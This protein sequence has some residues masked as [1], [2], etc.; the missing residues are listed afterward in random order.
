MKMLKK[1]IAVIVLF[2]TLSFIAGCKE[3]EIIKNPVKPSDGSSLT[4]SGLSGTEAGINANNSVFVD[5]SKDLQSSYLRRGWDLGFYCGTEFRVIINHS[6]GATA[7]ALDKTNLADVSDADLVALPGGIGSLDMGTAAISTV[8]PV[9]GNFTDYLANTVWKDVTT[10]NNKV[11]ILNRGIAG[12]I[13]TLET[14]KVQVT[15]ITGGYEVQYSTPGGIPGVATTVVKDQSYSFKYL[16][17]LSRSTLSVEPAKKLWD[18]EYTVTTYKDA[19]GLPVVAP[20]FILINFA[21][22]VTAAEIVFGSNTSK[23]YDSF[24]TADLSGVVFSGDRDAIG[25][26][27]RTTTGSTNSTLNIN[28]DRFYLI[29]DTEG[30]IYKLR[31]NGGQ[32]GKPEIQYARVEPAAL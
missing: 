4:L 28:T 11:F 9:A 10:A 7:I 27:W 6:A 32:R 3:E 21:N 26:K 23:N 31:F 14:M 18:I 19:A 2:G 8:D 25:V 29:R 13:D 15:R 20:D 5:L 1:S 24:G 30:N 22:G 12:G 16:S 17:F